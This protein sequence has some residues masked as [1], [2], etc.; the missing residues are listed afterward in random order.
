MMLSATR[1]LINGQWHTDK[2]LCIKDGKIARI[3]DRSES[4]PGTDM[5]SL[6]GDLVPGF[7]D[8]QVNGG[9]GALFNAEPTLASLQIMQLA[10]AQFG[11]TTMLPTLITDEFPVMV[12]AA[13]AMA[14]AIEQGVPGI[15]GIHFEGP[16]ISKERKGVHKS[17]FI[18]M[19]TD[20]EL[21]L[22]TR[23]DIGKVVITIAPEH[24]PVDIIR[25]LS[26]QGVAVCLGHSAATYEKA[27]A[28][29]DAGA[30]GFTHLFNA[31]S[32]MT[33]R[34]PGMVGAAF[35]NKKAYSGLVL[36]H[37]HVHPVS[38][39]IAID[40][41]GFEHIMLVTDAMAHVGTEDTQLPFFDT[42]ILRQKDKLTTPDG[43]LAGSC[44]DMCSAVRHAHRDLGVALEHAVAMASVTPATF[45][46]LQ[47]YLGDIAEGQQ[48]NLVL[49]DNS[50]RVKQV[51]IDGMLVHAA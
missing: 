25:D 38:S 42:R 13:A 40:S 51:Y 10:H 26:E 27:Q 36:D 32:P 11:T 7:I 31:M 22:F 48:A 35:A 5:I 47:S 20:A 30:S 21:A 4:F 28:A 15:A 16:F 29:L 37:Y 9:G 50:T 34:E 6:E 44:L 45:L 17:D 49:M 23:R 24:F 19:P 39:R 33:S 1:I 41:I 43:T 18:R 3:V 46:G 14:N 2:V 8:I 12:A